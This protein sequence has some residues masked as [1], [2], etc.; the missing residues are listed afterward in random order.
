[1]FERL[2]DQ[3]RRVVVWAQEEARML[4][5]NYIGTEHILLAIC[6]EPGN[7]AATLLTTFGVDHS[8]V[9]AQTVI[10]LRDYSGPEPRYANMQRR[11]VE[12]TERVHSLEAEI[13]RLTA[14]LKEHGIDPAEPGA[15]GSAS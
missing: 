12:L 1:M 4:N 5:H 13:T 6:R 3:A 15:A 14:L 11:V 7:E 10:L 2:T 8:K 9:M